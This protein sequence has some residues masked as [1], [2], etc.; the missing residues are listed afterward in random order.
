MYGKVEGSHGE[1]KRRACCFVILSAKQ[2]FLTYSVYHKP[3]KKQSSVSYGSGLRTVLVFLRSCT[4]AELEIMQIR[5]KMVKNARSIRRAL[6]KYWARRLPTEADI[7]PLRTL[8]SAVF[9]SLS[10]LESRGQRNVQICCR[11]FSS[12]KILNDFITM[13]DGVRNLDHAFLTTTPPPPSP[14]PVFTPHH[15]HWA[16]P[17]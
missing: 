17:L 3:S 16:L 9:W 4:R 6:R 8:L 15:I 7:L 5:A 14:P 13:G 1:A 10:W 2:L 11:K 12:K